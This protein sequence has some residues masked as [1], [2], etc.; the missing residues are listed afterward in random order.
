MHPSPKKITK[1]VI[2]LVLEI[3]LLKLPRKKVLAEVVIFEIG[4]C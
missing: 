4:K 3:N 2:P 1:H